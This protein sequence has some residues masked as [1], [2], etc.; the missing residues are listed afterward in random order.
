MNLHE[1]ACITLQLYGEMNV[2]IPS[3]VGFLTILLPVLTIPETLNNGANL[4]MNL[5]G[6]SL[7]A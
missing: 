1:N 6:A 3:D 7:F 5:L 2:T 4:Y